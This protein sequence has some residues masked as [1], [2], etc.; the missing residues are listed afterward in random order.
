MI[1]KLIYFALFILLTSCYTNNNNYEKSLKLKK[2]MSI[3]NLIKIMGEPDGTYIDSISQETDLTVYYYFP[4][5]EIHSDNIKVF[6]DS[7]KISRV[8]NDME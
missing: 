1:N 3:D 4:E 7:S 5:T 8:D 6:I 2:G